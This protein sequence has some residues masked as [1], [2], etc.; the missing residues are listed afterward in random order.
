MKAFLALTLLSLWALASD[1]TKV[2]P[3]AA[4]QKR[5]EE[6]HRDLAPIVASIESSKS[7][8]RVSIPFEPIVAAVADLNALPAGRRTVSLQS[9]RASGHFY[10]SKDLCNSY[11]ALEGPGDLHGSGVLTGFNAKP[12]DDGSL[13]LTAHTETSGHLQAHWQYFGLRSRRG[14]CPPGGGD[15]GSIGANFEKGLDFGVRIGFAMA[16]DG[17]TVAYQAALLNPR[18]VDIRMGVGIEHIGNLGLPAGFNLPGGTIGSGKFP[19]L[20]ATGGNFVVPG[21]QG[22]HSYSLAL[23][24]VS[25]AATK[26]G[27]AMEWTSS[28]DFSK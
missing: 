13:L 27:V 26:A 23:K 28:I 17:Q 1:K 5:I 8:V 24:P 4:Q 22:P 14:A 6:L 21:A 11:V 16:P 25:F 3:V 20:I 2:D 7:D 19:L 9:T 12:Q 18:R 15:G 10:D